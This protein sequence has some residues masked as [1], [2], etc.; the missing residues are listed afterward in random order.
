MCF[1]SSLHPRALRAEGTRN[2]CYY[3]GFGRGACPAI[4]RVC[5]IRG[6]ASLGDVVSIS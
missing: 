6:T 2:V 3:S 1:Y 4:L 5:V